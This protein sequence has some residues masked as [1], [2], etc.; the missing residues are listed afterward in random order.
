MSA[1]T[2]KL[3]PQMSLSDRIFYAAFSEVM[4]HIELLTEM[5]DVSLVGNDGV[6][7]EGRSI[8][9]NG[10]EDYQAFFDL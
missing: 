9:W 4:S 10:T 1:I 6:G 8:Q 5:G 7:G 2:Q 3:F